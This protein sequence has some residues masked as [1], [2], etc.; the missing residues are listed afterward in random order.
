[1][2]ENAE[3]GGREIAAHV[4]R[5]MESTGADFY[6]VIE[7]VRKHGADEEAAREELLEA[8]RQVGA[9]HSG[10]ALWEARH[11]DLQRLKKAPRTDE[12]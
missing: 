11:N 1:M 3:H 6:T 9:T 12:L 2:S 4:R 5:L 10:T 8:N 7:A